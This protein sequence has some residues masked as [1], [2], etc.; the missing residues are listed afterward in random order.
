M[1]T[2]DVHKTYMSEFIAAAY[3]RDDASEQKAS[4]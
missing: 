1:A 3:E 4:A 2:S